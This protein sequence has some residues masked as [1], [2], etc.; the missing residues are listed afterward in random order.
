MDINR[1][2]LAGSLSQHTATAAKT[3][4]RVCRGTFEHPSQ[5]RLCLMGEILVPTV[6]ILVSLGLSTRPGFH[7]LSRSFHFL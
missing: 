2:L 4:T 5:Q 6:P 3:S 1:H 7:S